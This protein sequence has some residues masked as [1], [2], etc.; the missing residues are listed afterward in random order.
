M[1]REQYQYVMKLKALATITCLLLNASPSMK[2]NDWPQWRGPQRNGISQE[3]GLLKEWPKDG[4]KLQWKAT[5]IGSGYS[6]PAVVGERLYVLANEGLENEFVEA[7]DASNGKRIWSAKLGRVGRPKQDPNFPAA[8][9]TP[10]VDGEVLYALG[11]DGD[12]ACIETGNGKIKWHKNVREDF[13]GQCGE[14]AY[15]ESPLI[16]GD[17]LVCTP[18]GKEATLLALNKKSGEVIWK[19]PLPGNDLA[20]YSSAVV[21]EVGGIRQCVQLLQKGLVGVDAR[22]GKFLWRYS[23]PISKYGANIPS[24]VVSGNSVYT[25]SAGTGGGMVKLQAKEEGVT[26][27]QVYFEAKLPTA[28]GGA[29]K[30]GD[31]LYGTT[32][33]ALLCVDFGTGEVK[34]QDR[35]LGAAS[36]C[37]ADGRLYL[38]GENGE[39]AL[40]EPGPEAYREKGRF[41]PPSPP[42]H[43][44]Q[45]ERAWAYPVVANGRLY[46]RDHG[47][48][49]C[50]D[51]RAN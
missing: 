35:A 17:V 38:H 22:T 30:S 14:W 3:T 13:G 11:S 49:W 26:P 18:G 50:Y 2:A 42:A 34:W 32:S 23:K 29:I 41:T 45:M 40:V 1:F 27:E 8:R 5:E 12:L 28:I 24:P 9:S 10:T 19:C 43:S 47:T 33:Q 37:Y 51:V 21:V 20:A 44:Q 25:A 6:T 16:D 46:V 7:L 15:S 48:L 39:V 4:P 36:L 31:Y